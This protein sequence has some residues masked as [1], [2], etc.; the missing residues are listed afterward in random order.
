MFSVC[1]ISTEL[2]K[3]SQDSLPSAFCFLNAGILLVGC[4]MFL[5]IHFISVKYK[6]LVNAE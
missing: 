6:L 5:A 4:V 2:Y 1:P 3:V